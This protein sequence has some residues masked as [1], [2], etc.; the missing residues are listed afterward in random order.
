MFCAVAFFSE[1]AF[2]KWIVLYAFL[3]LFTFMM[4]IRSSSACLKEV[5]L[6]IE[7]TIIDLQTCEN[8]NYSGKSANCPLKT[9]W[10]PG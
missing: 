2:Q 5:I 1:M 7:K 10:R 9:K 4:E 3:S 6:Q 8:W